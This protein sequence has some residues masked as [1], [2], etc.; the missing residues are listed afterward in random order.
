[1]TLAEKAGIILFISGSIAIIF[2]IP[3]IE[4]MAIGFIICI[5]GGLLFSL[6]DKI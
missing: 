2:S 1:M 3:S 5:V 4:R 6:G